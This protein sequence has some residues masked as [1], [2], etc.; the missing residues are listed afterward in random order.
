MHKMPEVDEFVIIGVDTHADTHVAVL[1]NQMGQRLGGRAFP[2]TRA[3][4]GRL[5]E[6]ANL[7]GTIDRIGIEGTGS[8]GRG[9]TLFCL[10]RG[11]AVRDVDRPDR[12]TRRRVGKTDLVDAE[13][14]ARAVLAGTAG[15][16]PKTGNGPV[17]MIRVLAA[18]GCR[19]RIIS[20]GPLPVLGNVPA[21]PANTAGAAASAGA[22]SV[23]P[24]R[25]RVL[26]SGR[27]T[28]RT[29]RPRERQKR[30]AAAQL[31]GA[32]DH[33]PIDRAEPVGPLEQ[34]GIAGTSGGEAAAEALAGTWLS[35][36]ATCRSAC[37]STP[38][39]T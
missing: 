6:W 22:R 34:P 4:Y 25:R 7:H 18:H 31:P 29:A 1:L 28:S 9:L 36:T 5:L 39:M 11:L 26:R 3:G 16:L 35:G 37:V 10:S 32:L 13:A 21:M 12:K 30:Q 20:T 8:W 33:D 38:T 23:L 19:T 24:T 17:E 15:T 14:A 2:A 27:S